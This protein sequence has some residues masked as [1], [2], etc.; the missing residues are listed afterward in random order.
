M[1]ELIDPDKHIFRL[2]LWLIAQADDPGRIYILDFPAGKLLPLFEEEATALDY[3]ERHPLPGYAVIGMAS[4]DVLEQ[5]LDQCE[6]GKVFHVNLDQRPGGGPAG[7]PYPI[8]TLRRA[9]Q[10]D[11]Q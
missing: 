2:P 10:Q 8:E 5:I 1:D 4:S 3:I 9:L 11:E 6:E 7:R